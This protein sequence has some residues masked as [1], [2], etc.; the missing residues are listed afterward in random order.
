MFLKVF[1]PA[2]T[3]PTRFSNR[4]CTLIDNYLCKLCH[5][6]TQSTSGIFIN[7][8]SDH[9]P[10]FIFLD[11]LKYKHRLSDNRGL[12]RIQKWDVHCVHKFNIELNN[13]SIYELMNKT[14][15]A[16]PNENLNILNRIISQAKD[17]HL[18]LRY[19]KYDKHKHKKSLWIT[20]GIIRSITFRDK[21][22]LQLKRSPAGSDQHT[23]LKM[24]LNT[25]KLHLKRLIRSAKKNY[26]QGQFSKFKNDIKNTWRTIK[27]II[28]RDQNSHDLPDELLIDNSSTCDPSIIAN[29]FNYFFAGIGSKLAD[30]INNPD[31]ANFQDYLLN[32]SIHNSVFECIS[33]ETTME[34]LNKLKSK[35]SYGHDGISTKLLKACTNEICKSLTLVINQALTSCIFPETLK[36]ANVI[37]IFFKGDKSLLDNYRPIS[38]LPSVSKIFER[39][40]FN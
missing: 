4:N 7:R 9:L 28:N 17:K 37:P 8:I 32:P 22:Y 35:P 39:A 31:N 12:I 36:I 29:K 38:I 24:N 19:V 11:N 33:E 26:Y 5:G 18:H 2:I 13:A 20:N 27:Q 21:L 14:I 16:D 1:F 25:Y 6:F 40:M 15:D 3:L 34:L 10:Y 30:A 23:V